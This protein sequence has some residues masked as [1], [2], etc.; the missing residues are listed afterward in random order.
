ML[1][2]YNNTPFN[3]T[4]KVDRVDV[5]ESTGLSPSFNLINKPPSSMAGIVQVGNQQYKQSAGKFSRTLTGFTLAETP[6]ENA[7]V[8]SPGVIRFVFD[9]YDQ[10]NIPGQSNA[11]IK[12]KPIFL[13]DPEHIADNQYENALENSKILLSAYD[14]DTDYGAQATWMQFCYSDPETGEPTND[15]TDPGE[16]LEIQN[17]SGFSILSAP[18]AALATKVF[19]DD[20]TQFDNSDTV[21]FLQFEPGTQYQEDKQV[22]SINHS[23]GEVTLLTPLTYAHSAG[24]MVYHMGV[25]VHGKLTVPIPANGPINYFDVALKVVVDELSRIG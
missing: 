12:V 17:I 25:G 14:N 8:I 15:W 4:T 20:D 16:P 2:L 22:S 21:M 24:A 23:T 18:A 11:N 9:A 3:Y 5:F 6:P 7:I 19:V 10:A 13:C 1:W